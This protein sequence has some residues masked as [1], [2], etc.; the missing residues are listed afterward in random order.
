MYEKFYGFAQSPFRMSPDPAFYYATARHNEALANLTYGVLMQKGFIV[1]TGEV[2][3]GKTLLVR[4]LLDTLHRSRVAHAYI[5]NPL[6]SA[7][8]LLRMILTDFGI[9]EVKRTRGEMLQQFN[10]HLI[11]VYRRNGICALVIDEAHLLAPMLLEEIR[12]ITNIETSKHKLLQIVLVGQPELD[13]NLDSP[14]LRQV[15]QRISLRYTLEPMSDMEVRGYIDRRL[16]V[17]G[18]PNRLLQIFPAP[19]LARILHYAHGIPRLVNTLC[20]NALISGYG[21]HAQSIQPAIIDEVA[22]DLRLSLKNSAAKMTGTPMSS[23]P[24][25][26]EMSRKTLVRTLLRLARLLEPGAENDKNQGVAG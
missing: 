1:L 22:Q 21:R 4:C 3:T 16:E 18:A 20:D 26:D 17:A 14:E 12:L 5:L 6:L 15:K 8:D 10:E 11:E 24:G 2:G 13:E 23:K 25:D 7:D 9:R 19:T